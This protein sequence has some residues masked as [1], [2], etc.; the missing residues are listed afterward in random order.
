MPSSPTAAEGTPDSAVPLQ[1][2]T[3]R[4]S[5]ATLALLRQYL[6][7]HD[8]TDA[9]SESTPV[10]EPIFVAIDV[11]AYERATSKVTEVG[12]ATLDSRTL[13]SPP[14]TASDWTNR[15][16][17][18]HYI[19]E[20]HKHLINKRFVKGCPDKFQFGRS[21]HVPLSQMRSIF[22]DNFSIKDESI[23]AS[24][25]KEPLRDIVL[26]GHEMPRLVGLVDTQKLAVALALPNGLQTLLNAIGEK[27]EYLHNGGNDANWT[28]QS[29]LFLALYGSVFP[30]PT[31]MA[32]ARQ[33]RAEKIRIQEEKQ[34]IKK[35]K[36]Q[37]VREAEQGLRSPSEEVE[38]QKA[39]KLR[40]AKQALRS[41]SEEVKEQMERTEV[42]VDQP[43]Q[44]E[45][46]G[47]KKLDPATLR[48]KKRTVI[49]E[50]IQLS[51]Q[52]RPKERPAKDNKPK[53]SKP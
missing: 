15:I 8:Q 5:P 35:Q 29:A 24:P 22:R 26:V 9:Q 6:G 45:G 33:V 10:L 3:K 32:I 20:E 53:D 51:K 21:R 17:T 50:R 48:L 37:E 42:A 4:P 19:I 11:E 30:E 27:P 40:E 1:R 34:A 16:H 28:M 52:S 14:A 12:I 44:A 31:S 2:P 23:A 41:Q 46:K 49:R 25:G 13:L 43:T 36:A 7:L 39:Q 18:K 47:K 38:K